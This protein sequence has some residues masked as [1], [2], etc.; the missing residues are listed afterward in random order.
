[1]VICDVHLQGSSSISKS[2]FYVGSIPSGYQPLTYSI[3]PW[4][5][6]TSKGVITATATDSLRCNNLEAATS[7]LIVTQLVWYTK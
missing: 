5:N 3:S 6:A 1:M 4:V 7:N 2:E